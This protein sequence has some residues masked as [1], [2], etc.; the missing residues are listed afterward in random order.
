MAQQLGVHSEVG[1]L[2]QAIVHRPGLELSRLTPSN[3]DEL[4]F[5]DVLWAAKAREEHDTFA[6]LLR[7]RGVTVHHFH[8]LLA[9]TL[10]IP[11]ARAFVL[12]RIC[13]AEQVGPTLAVPLRRFADEADAETLAELLV[14]GVTRS[15]LSPMRARSLRW[16]TLGLDDFVLP[17]LPNTLFQRDNS[18]WVYGGVTI[19]PMAKAARQRESLHS[20]AVY[21]FHPALGAPDSVSVLLEDGQ[22]DGAFI[23][24]A[25]YATGS[26]SQ[27]ALM[28]ATQQMQETQMSFNLQYLEL[29]N[30]MQNENRQFTMV[31]NIMKTK[32][33]TVKNSISN[34]R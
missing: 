15:D 4:L 12:D 29:Q 1:R 2:R 30:Q 19:N 9:Q 10:E 17:P 31:S 25:N 26:S 32:H 3:C 21:R 11:A 6:Q 8:D 34:I 7:E 23:G 16:Q 28:Q 33:D 24:L 14:G 20:R 5:D 18:A 27:G 13:S 22:T